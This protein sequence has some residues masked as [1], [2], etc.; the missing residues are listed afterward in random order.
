MT[1]CL[2]FLRLGE[3]I[4][5]A[6]IK[7]GSC[8]VAWA[9]SSSNYIWPRWSRRGL[10]EMEA[11]FGSILLLQQL[12]AIASSSQLHPYTLLLGEGQLSGLMAFA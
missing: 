2:L 12:P 4:N 1:A 3:L 6:E 8:G 11:L 9:V 10:L 7:D 5:A